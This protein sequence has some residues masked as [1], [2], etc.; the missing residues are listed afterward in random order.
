MKATKQAKSPFDYKQ[1]S[2]EN[3]SLL[4]KLK[5]PYSPIITSA[6]PQISFYSNTLAHTPLTSRFSEYCDEYDAF[7]SKGKEKF[8]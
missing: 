5:R 8:K 3:D 6:H 7:H 2:R 4:Q 1:K